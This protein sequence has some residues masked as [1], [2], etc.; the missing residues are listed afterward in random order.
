MLQPGVSLLKSQWNLMLF[1]FTL[2]MWVHSLYFE[3]QSLWQ[4]KGLPYCFIAASYIKIQPKRCLHRW[5]LYAPAECQS[6]FTPLC[7][8]LL[9]VFWRSQTWHMTQDKQ[10]QISPSVCP[11]VWMCAL[12]MW[13]LVQE[14]VQE[15]LHQVKQLKLVSFSLKNFLITVKKVKNNFVLVYSGGIT[16]STTFTTTTT[17]VSTVTNT[18]SGSNAS[19]DEP[20]QGDSTTLIGTIVILLHTSI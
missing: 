3:S 2:K 6:S 5:M 14:T 8:P 15:Y 16:D 7:W 4:F 9:E 20:Q 13:G 17:T 11:R 19:V 12:S 10:L 18:Q 1:T